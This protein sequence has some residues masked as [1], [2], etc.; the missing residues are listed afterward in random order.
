MGLGWKMDFV[1]LEEGFLD[2]LKGVLGFGLRWCLE[3][4]GSLVVFF[5]LEGILGF[6]R[7]FGGLTC[8]QMLLR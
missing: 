7:N 5:I 4:F 2:V 8:P 1:D 6:L 3:E